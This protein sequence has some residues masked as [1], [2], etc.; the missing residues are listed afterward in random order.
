MEPDR[1]FAEEPARGR[2]VVARPVFIDASLRIELASRVL[3][4]VGERAR[5][6]GQLSKGV[7]AVGVGQWTRKI[8]QRSDRI[9][10]VLR[11]IA[12]RPCAEF[13]QRLVNQ[14]KSCVTC[15]AI[16]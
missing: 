3:E 15:I 2:V 14:R 5:G 10:C 11:V 9:D 7:V 8:A 4:W 16:R 13:G 6:S 12:G 1:V